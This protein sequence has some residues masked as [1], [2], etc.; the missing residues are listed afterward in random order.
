[1]NPAATYILEKPEPFRSILLHV[2]AI[3]EFTVP[4][5]ALKYKYKIPFY[6]L[7]DR[8]FCYLNVTKGYVDVGFWKANA[9]EGYEEYWVTAGRKMIKSLRYMELEAVQDEV[10]VGILQGSAALYD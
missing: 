4:T 7:N 2:Q 9:I 10:L 6:D 5:V 3:I 8:P 1:M